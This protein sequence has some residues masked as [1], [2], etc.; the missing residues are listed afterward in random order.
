MPWFDHHVDLGDAWK[1]W[2]GLPFVFAVWATNKPETRGSVP[3]EPG[4]QATGHEHEDLSRILSEARDRGVARAAEIAVETG[5]A[6]GWPVELAVEYMTHALTY[7]I[8]P[9]AE[10]GMN[11]YFELLDQ[12]QI[13]PQVGGSP[14]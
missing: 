7:K 5:P 14:A 10:A 6:H 3:S 9:A 2:T 4:A 12:A 8:T 1:K 11:R 13:V